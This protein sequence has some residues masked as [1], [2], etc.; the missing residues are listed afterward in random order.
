MATHYSMRD[1]DPAFWRKVK[2][3][4]AADGKS[5]RSIILALLARWLAVK[6]RTSCR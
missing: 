4:A 5:V 3:Q 2:M 1:L 6:E